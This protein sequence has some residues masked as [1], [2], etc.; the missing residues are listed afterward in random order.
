MK[1][2]HFTPPLHQTLHG[3]LHLCGEANSVERQE[4]KEKRQ[5]SETRP[6]PRTRRERPRP[7]THR[8]SRALRVAPAL[9]AQ[10]NCARVWAA[11]RISKPVNQSEEIYG[12]GKETTRDRQPH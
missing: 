6:K 8:A 12:A 9:G 10:W 2:R 1:R 3:W 7:L 5:T 11:S 4:M